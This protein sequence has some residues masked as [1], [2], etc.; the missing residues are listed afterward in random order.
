MA[1]ER[2]F[3]LAIISNKLADTL[4]FDDVISE[5][6]PKKGRKKTLK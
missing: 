6:A 1:Q 3:S 4:N 5:F 2:L